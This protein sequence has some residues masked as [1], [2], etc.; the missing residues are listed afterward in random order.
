VSQGAAP[1]PF[2]FNGKRTTANLYDYGA[3]WYDPQMGRFL[4][5]DPV[6]LDPYDPQGLSRYSYVRNDPVGR[7]DPTGAW[8]LRGNVYAGQVDEHGFTGVVFGFGVQNGGSYRVSGGALVGG[9][10]IAQFTRSLEKLIGAVQV[11]GAFQVFNQIG[12]FFAR[13]VDPPAVSAGPP[14]PVDWRTPANLA[15]LDSLD[16]YV[17]N[18]AAQHLSRLAAEGIPFRLTEGFRSYETQNHYY[19]QGRTRP[20]PIITDARGGESFHNFG[21]AYDVSLLRNG[22]LV[23]NGRDPL[24]RRAKELSDGVSDGVGDGR[25][26]WGGAWGDAVHFQFRGGVP[27]GTIRDRYDKGEPLW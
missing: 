1:T 8:S 2:G 27:I 14:A 25:L 20:G 16:P 12:M 11:S 18:L 23:Q 19:A 4:Q 10:P 13:T 6:I 9:V 24:Y 5:P 7:T 21:L 22:K 17:A 15:V 26:E 3:R